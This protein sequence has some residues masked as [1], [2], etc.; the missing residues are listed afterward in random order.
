MSTDYLIVAVHPP[1]ARNQLIELIEAE[2]VEFRPI[3]A[4]LPGPNLKI[5]ESLTNLIRIYAYVESPQFAAR[6]NH[7]IWAWNSASQ[8][9]LEQQLRNNPDIDEALRGRGLEALGY[10]PDGSVPS[11]CNQIRTGV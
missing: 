5:T 2:F 11:C 6:S 10:L 9:W 1:R 7:L 8:Y 3:V 4:F